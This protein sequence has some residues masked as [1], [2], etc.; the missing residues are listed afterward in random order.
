[1]SIV[2]I[3][4]SL[5][6]SESTDKVVDAAK[7][8]AEAM[9]A[10]LYLM[11]VAEPEPDFIG[12]GVGPQTVRDS[13]SEEFHKE[14]ALIQE[15]AESLRQ[16]GLDATSLLIQGSTVEAILKQADKLEAQMIVMGSHGRGAI[17]KVLV[18]SVSEGVL[19]GSKCP[20]LVVPTHKR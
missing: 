3:L 8:L 4:V 14:H 5:D 20:V 18:G 13:V 11:H 19:Q 2:N 6:I 9:S 7:Q 15:L 10:K 1:V 12:Y 16:K 17:Y